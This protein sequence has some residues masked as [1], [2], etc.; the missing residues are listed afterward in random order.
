MFAVKTVEILNNNNVRV[1]VS[2]AVEGGNGREATR[3]RLS[4]EVRDQTWICP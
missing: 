2:L 3:P 4:L 1:R